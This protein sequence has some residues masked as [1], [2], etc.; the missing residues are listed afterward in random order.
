VPRR[1]CSGTLSVRLSTPGLNSPQLRAPSATLGKQ[2][3]SRG[4]YHTRCL[5][6]LCIDLI[7]PTLTLLIDNA[8]ID[9][10]A[11]DELL[12]LWKDAGEMFGMALCKRLEEHADLAEPFGELLNALPHVKGCCADAII[13]EPMTRAQFDPPP[14]LAIPHSVVADILLA[15][16]VTVSAEVER[17]FDTFVDHLWKRTQGNWVSLTTFVTVLDQHLGP[18]SR[19]PRLLKQA[20]IDSTFDQLAG[21]RKV[22]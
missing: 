7:L 14:E 12:Q 22:W 5:F 1:C 11:L 3:T 6:R 2:S 9:L 19:R 10:T 17:R 21:V 16:E 4:C 20:M 13:I 15:L 8:D 18:D